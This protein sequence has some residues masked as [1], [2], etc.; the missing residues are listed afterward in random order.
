MPVA[1]RLT[2]PP[3][4]DIPDLDIPD[5]IASTRSRP[6]QDM[7]LAASDK[8]A[9]RRAVASSDCP[10]CEVLKDGQQVGAIV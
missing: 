2:E 4:L 9:L 6:F 7:S 8:E 5:V 3:D 1:A 10:V